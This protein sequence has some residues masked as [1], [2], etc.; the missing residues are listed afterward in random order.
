MFQAEPELEREGHGCTEGAPV[1][2]QGGEGLIP[3][4]AER[5]GF[6]I[7]PQQSYFS[8]EREGVFI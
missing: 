6:P 7:N 8:I 3:G 4:E 1:Q 5:I 2:R